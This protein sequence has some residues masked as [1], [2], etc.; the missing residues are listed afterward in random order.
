MQV[1]ALLPL[2]AKRQRDR[3]IAQN[4]L[5]RPPTR[6]RRRQPRLSGIMRDRRRGADDRQPARQQ[7]K[8]TR[9]PLFE[10]E[11]SSQFYLLSSNEGISTADSN[12]LSACPT[13]NIRRS[14][15]GSRIASCF[16]PPVTGRRVRDGKTMADPHRN[17][18]STR[19]L[20]HS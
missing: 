20:L 8:I 10:Q 4:G 9:R 17:T 14:D 1:R 15:A 19:L 12:P 3:P 6:V 11:P 2:S 18:A 16:P 5:C 13:A 7:K